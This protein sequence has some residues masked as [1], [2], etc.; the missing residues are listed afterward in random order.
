MFFYSCYINIV[1]TTFT[2]ENI[3]NV[4][5]PE[6]PAE[7]TGKKQMLLIV[8]YPTVLIVYDF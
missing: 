6:P 4:T 1:R 7:E 2:E 3:S 5:S 8:A